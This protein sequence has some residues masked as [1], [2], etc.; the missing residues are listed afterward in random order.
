MLIVAG[1]INTPLDVELY[2]KGKELS[3]TKTVLNRTKDKLGKG[4]VH[5]ALGD[6]LY[7]NQYHLSQ[8]KYEVGCEA[9]VKTE[10]E[11]L[12]IIWL[13]LWLFV[14]LYLLPI[15]LI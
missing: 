3:A 8:C 5:I 9:L 10:D 1:A 11:S 13:K 12:T 6:G 7:M 14:P 2:S 15:I 4:F